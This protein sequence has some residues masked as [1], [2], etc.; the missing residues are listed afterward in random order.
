[1]YT[2]VSWGVEAAVADGAVNTAHAVS[3]ATA[4]AV[5]SLFI[6]SPWILIDEYVNPDRTLM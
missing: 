5:A 6:A 1:V 3:A 4:T 2:V